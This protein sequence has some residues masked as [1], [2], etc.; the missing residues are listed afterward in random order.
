ML[1]SLTAVTMVFAL[2]GYA[3]AEDGDG[4]GQVEYVAFAPTIDQVPGDPLS[5][6][7]A[8]ETAWF[9][10]ELQRTDGNVDPDV[11]YGSCGSR[12]QMLAASSADA[13]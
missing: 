4:G 3:Y 12:G 13:D 9:E 10:R 5:C 6:R 7:E 1:K 2:C 8:R 11:Q